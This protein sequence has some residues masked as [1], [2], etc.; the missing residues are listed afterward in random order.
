[1]R[2]TFAFVAFF[3]VALLLASSTASDGI[4]DG[5]YKKPLDLPSGGAAGEDE[6]EDEEGV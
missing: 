5:A 2:F 1:M 6:E 3:A 4:G